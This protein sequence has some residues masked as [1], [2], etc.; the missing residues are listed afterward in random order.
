M[1]ERLKPGDKV[2]VA[3]GSGDIGFV[4]QDVLN[5]AYPGV[6]VVF[7]GTDQF[8]GVREDRL[9]KVGRYDS[10]VEDP[11]SCGWGM[12]AAACRYLTMTAEGYECAR[13][14]DKRNLI[15]FSRMTAQAY[16]TKFKPDCQEEIM[17]NARASQV[18]Q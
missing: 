6:P 4:A 2:E 13:F 1:S 17:G 3:G 9:K 15:I 12:G 5:A 8:V 14:S 11:E 10:I 7:E 16:P 18:E